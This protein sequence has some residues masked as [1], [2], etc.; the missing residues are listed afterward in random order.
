MPDQRLIRAAQRSAVLFAVLAGSSVGFVACGPASDTPERA[1]ASAVGYRPLIQPSVRLSIE[2]G[3]TLDE[4]LAR[5]GVSAPDVR[6]LLDVVRP[7]SD[8]TEPDAAVEARFHRWPGE[9]PERIELKVDRDLTLD[10]DVRGAHWEMSLDS[11]VATL[12]TVVV[13]GTLESSL[14]AAELSGDDES[15]SV[16]EMAALPGLLAEVYA[17]QIDFYRDPGPGD[18]FRLAIEREIRSDGSLRGSTVIAAEYATAERLLQAYRFA[19]TEGGTRLYFDERGVGLR[20][21]FLRAPLDLVRVTSRFAT[22][23]YH[24]VLGSYRSH[25]GLDYGAPSGTPVRTTGDG[26]VV[27]AG[28]AGDFGLMIEVDHGS[29]IRTRYA[30]LSGVAD[31]VHLG[32]TVVQGQ[33]IGAVGSTGLSTASHLHYEFRRHGRALDPSSVDLPVERPISQT[34]EPRFAEAR[35]VARAVLGRSRW[36]AGIPDARHGSTDS[37]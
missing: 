3:E 25:N 28:W 16:A 32:A 37:P 31:E 20:G 2:P 4:F 18:A 30:H 6:R 5:G 19:P 23:R 22:G 7:Y 13:S 12:D 11:V 9:S 26:R 24:P 27:R 15:L 10:L 36:P 17:W 21:A 34:E 14:Y 33:V 1:A 35:G 29:G 8:W